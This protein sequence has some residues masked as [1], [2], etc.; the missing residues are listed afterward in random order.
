MNFIDG[1]FDVSDGE[2]ALRLTEGSLVHLNGYSFK[3]RVEQGQAIVLGLRPEQ[4]FLKEKPPGATT[5]PLKFSVDEPMGAETLIW[6][7]L[8]KDMVSARVAPDQTFSPSE[9]LEAHFLPNQ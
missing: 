1:Q 8:G 2:T 9:F 5:L 3:E 7:N 4:I 6:S